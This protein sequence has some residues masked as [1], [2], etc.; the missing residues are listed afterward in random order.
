VF[1]EVLSEIFVLIRVNLPP[2]FPDLVVEDGDGFEIIALDVELL[3]LVVLL[4]LRLLSHRGVVLSV[5]A[6]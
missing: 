4:S 5:G 3:D 1:V 6:R 2:G